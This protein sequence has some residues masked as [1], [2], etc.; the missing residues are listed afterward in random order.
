M[1]EDLFLN[2]WFYS[3]IWLN[4]PHFFYIFL[5]MLATLATNKKLLKTTLVHTTSLIHIAYPQPWR[6]PAVGRF[7]STGVSFHILAVAVERQVGYL[8]PP[9]A[10]VLLLSLPC[11]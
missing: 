1:I 9:T 3:Q 7:C 10:G 2:I 4:L 5:W 6:S 8:L 11:T